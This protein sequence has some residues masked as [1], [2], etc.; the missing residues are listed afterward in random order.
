MFTIIMYYN[1][2]A[3]SRLEFYAPPCKMQGFIDVSI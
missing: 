3:F 2:S 1:Q